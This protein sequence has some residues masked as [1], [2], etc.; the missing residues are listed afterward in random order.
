M[1]GLLLVAAFAVVAMTTE[2]FDLKV[3]HGCDFYGRMSDG[4]WHREIDNAN[5][6]RAMVLLY[7]RGNAERKRK[8]KAKVLKAT[9]QRQRM[10]ETGEMDVG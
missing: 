5:E 7:M 2:A 4:E 3:Y 8:L 10:G 6:D 9:R 1:I